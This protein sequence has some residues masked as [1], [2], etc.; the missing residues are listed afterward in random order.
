MEAGS[1]GTQQATAAISG[2][3]QT[4]DVFLSATQYKTDGIS[5]ANVNDGNTEKD[6]YQNQDIH[7]RGGVNILPDLRLDL[8]LKKV[9]TDTQYDGYP[10]PNYSL[11]DAQ[12]RTKG[13]QD[14]AKIKLNWLSEDAQWEHSLG[15]ERSQQDHQ[16]YKE[17]GQFDRQSDSQKDKQSYQGSYYFAEDS[18]PQQLTLALEKETD[19]YH[20]ETAIAGEQQ[21]NTL[22]GVVE[23]GINVNDSFYSTL[24]LRQDD[25][26][27][28]KTANTYRIALTAWASD[29]VR[30]HAS[31]G[32]GVKNPSFIELYGY[33]SSTLGNPD[34]RQEQ[35]LT[36]DLGL[37][38]HFESLDGFADITLFHSDIDNLISY[39][40]DSSTF[41][42]KN[43]NVAKASIKGAELSLALQANQQHRLNASYTYTDTDDGKG[44][45][46]ARRASHI[47][48]LN[49]HFLF[50]NDKTSLTTGWQYNGKQQ[51]A[52]E[53]LAAFNLVNLALAHNYSKQFSLYARVENL[54]DTDYEEVAGFG[55]R[56]RSFTLG[57]KLDGAL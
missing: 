3:T 41:K 6:G 19:R 40:Y 39:Q 29:S 54:L 57:I 16:H 13:E 50:A 27:Q 22:S 42:G 52:G 46:L 24:A 18:Y 8:V 9:Q 37:E 1:F 4:G 11:T 47:A 36:Q 10:A 21:I 31:Q 12:N 56:G 33:G 38:Y 32:T 45:S 35:N 44:K 49:H 23:Y 30:L 34:L 20:N 14:A 48:S 17:N 51:D 2:G 15:L 26:D 53:T 7:F 28:Y 43:F 25:S 55:T 5:A